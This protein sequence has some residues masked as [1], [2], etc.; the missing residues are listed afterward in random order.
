M[1][2]VEAGDGRVVVLGPQ[3]VD[4]AGVAGAALG[5]RRHLGDVDLGEAGPRDGDADLVAR[6][7]GAGAGGAGLVV[8]GVG[9][10]DEPDTVGGE[11]L[12]G[13]REVGGVRQQSPRG[14]DDRVELEVG[15]VAVGELDEGVAVDEGDRLGGGPVEDGGLAVVLELAEDGRPRGRQARRVHPGGGEDDVVAAGDV[16]DGELDG[17]VGGAD[18]AHVVLTRGQVG[19]ADVDVLAVGQIE[20]GMPAGV[21]VPVGDDD[22]AGEVLVA[23]GGEQDMVVVGVG[24]GGDTLA[25][26]DVQFVLADHGREGDLDVV[27]DHP[28]AA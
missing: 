19:V 26:S 18:D 9:L 20:G 27:F 17:V 16:L 15:R 28:H 10:T 11:R 14:E 21:V 13:D 2:R 23:I 25:V 8:A 22:R 12:V 6:G 7:D 24:D 5:R 4:D 3:L 1:V